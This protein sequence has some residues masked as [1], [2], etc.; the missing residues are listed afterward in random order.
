MSKQGNYFPQLT[1]L[2]AIAAYLVYL[3]HYPI[4]PFE[5][6]FSQL[7]IG[8]G[9]FFTLSGF[10]IY[11]RYAESYSFTKRWWKTYMINRFARIYP[12]YFLV[13]IVALSYASGSLFEW[14]AHLTLLRGFFLGLAHTGVEQGWT[15]SIE[16]CFYLSA[17]FLFLA[18]SRGKFWSPLFILYGIGGLLTL[19]GQY[20]D[21]YGFFASIAFTALN[22]YFGRA[23]E[24]FLGMY[25]AKK[26]L[27][28]RSASIPIAPVAQTWATFAGIAGIIGLVLLKTWLYQ[29]IGNEDPLSIA[30]NNIAFPLC[31]SFLL[32]GLLT[33]E[34]IVSRFL[35][36]P[37][38]VLLGKSSYAFYLIHIGVFG[39]IVLFISTQ[40][41][42]NN[43]LALLLHFL[44][45]NLI[46]IGLFHYIEEPLNRLI[47][48]QPWSKKKLALGFTGDKEG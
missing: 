15:L 25:L 40:I 33:E 47:R 26:F 38:M 11:Y 28:S 23:L 12:L 45:M 16:E 10:L 43:H 17:P 1:G 24:F 5:D 14:F 18:F 6:V 8:V 34:T 3:F 31:N 20:I 35:A 36:S 30:L 7:Y 46:S 27:A 4:T 2:R 22:T 29:G 19:L 48:T 42:P 13:T 44:I 32:W 21:Y 41:I 39:I 9:I 37:F